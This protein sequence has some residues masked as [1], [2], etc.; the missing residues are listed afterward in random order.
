LC[1]AL[2]G[3]EDGQTTLV[4]LE[5]AN[6]FIVS[7][8]D[9]RRWYRYHH[10]F[11]DLLRVRLRQSH[12]EKIPTLQIRASEWFEQNGFTSDAIEYAL[13]AEGFERAAIL[14]EDVADEVWVRGEF[15]KMAGWLD[16]L[17]KEL[18]FSKPQ[19]CIFHA[20]SLFVSGRLNEAEERLQNAER[21]LYQKRSRTCDTTP[22]DLLKNLTPDQMKMRGRIAAA[23]AGMAF[24]QGDITG[25]TQ[26][27]SEAFEYLPGDDLSWRSLAANALADAQSFIGDMHAAYRTRSDALEISR[28]A[29]NRY[30]A[31]IANLKL[32]IVLRQQGKL[33]Q[34]ID[35]CQEEMQH[36]NDS[37]MS[38]PVTLGLLLAIWGEA[39]VEIN[40]LDEAI[41]KTLKGLELSEQGGDIAG[42]GWSSYSLIRALFSTGDLTGAEKV[43]QKME[44]NSRGYD[45][46]PW[47]SS[48]MKGWRVRIW[49]AKGDFD[50][51]YR[52]AE[53]Y[54]PDL[55]EE[56]TPLNELE[57]FG[58]VRVLIHQGRFGDAISF[59]QSLLD[60]VNS[61]GRV[62]RKLELLILKSFT[63]QALDENDKALDALQ[64]AL[65][66]GRQGGFFRVFVDEGPP[67]ARLLYQA[68]TLG[69]AP[70]YVQRLLAAFPEIEPEQTSPLSTQA[71]ES[72]LIEPL[73]KRELEV[74][75]LIAEGLTNPEIASRL[76]LSPHTVKTH[77]HNIYG[78]LG[79][80]NRTQAV[81]RA[82][83]LG[84]L[85]ST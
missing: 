5:H 37:G 65:V 36:A 34:V 52:W 40:E 16:A 63:L 58:L 54:Q 55:Y 27:A 45:I 46:P 42:I 17:P 11:G 25:L 48:I 4:M 77:T 2:T 81:T 35:I 26:Y 15:K 13:R 62:W 85:P 10:L 12:P 39:L 72:D 83:V 51:A 24:Y 80:H 31:T 3:Q 68:L 76:F 43:I 29:G 47:I 53:R 44:N 60:T 66:I 84:V 30:Q 20:S 57:H 74:L 56:L 32:V 50:K 79:V 23:R 78:K 73:S 61:L 49:L 71:P 41:H 18:L 64:Q 33:Q 9:E 82:R 70:E 38:H 21:A 1:D 8:D 22:G 75:Q 28:A 69:M 19:L 6:L 59:L 7:L 67:M 14:L